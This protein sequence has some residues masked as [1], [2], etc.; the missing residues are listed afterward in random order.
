LMSAGVLALLNINKTT[1]SNILTIRHD[2]YQ[3]GG[4][5]IR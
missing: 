4:S 3:S 1:L 2:Q 5:D